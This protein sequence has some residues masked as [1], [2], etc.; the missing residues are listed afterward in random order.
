VSP[1]APAPAAA[2]LPTE[3][4]K[5]LSAIEKARAAK[6]EKDA[7]AKLARARSDAAAAPPAP[8]DARTLENA[9]AGLWLVLQLLVWA[10]ARKTHELDDLAPLDIEKDAAALMAVVKDRTTLVR[11]LSWVGAPIVLFRRVREKLHR[12]AAPVVPLREV[13]P[14]PSQAP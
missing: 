10:Y 5:A 9:Y 11:I 8:L 13:Q 7:A 3:K 6:A 14:G 1:V 2:P 4:G 12:K